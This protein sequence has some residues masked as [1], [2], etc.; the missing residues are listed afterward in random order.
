VCTEEGGKINTKQKGIFDRK[1]A[2]L[3]SWSRKAGKLLC[4][5]LLPPV[6]YVVE[7]HIRWK[8]RDS[9]CADKV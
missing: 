9:S 5:V 8:E 4:R 2:T 3:S 6:N 1:K 7:F